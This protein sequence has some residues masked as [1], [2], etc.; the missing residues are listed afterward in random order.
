MALEILQQS[1]ANRLL[2]ALPPDEFESLRSRLEPIKLELRASLHEPSDPTPYVHFPER[3]VLSLLTVLE[4]GWSVELGTV[5]NE[6]MVDIS[7]ALG[8]ENSETQTI[9]QVPGQALRMKSEA[10]RDALMEL[11]GLRRLL[12]AYILEVF[13]MTAQSNACNRAHNLGQRAARWLLMTHDRVDADDFPL[14]QEFLSDM[15]G[16]ARPGVTV[17]MEQLRDAGLIR[18]R[19][20]RLDVIDRTGLEKVSCECY[21]LIRARFDRLE[22]EGPDS[23]GR[24]LS[25]GLLATRL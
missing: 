8:K 6:G 4:N 2:R 18:Y 22:G 1:M 3:G 10:F 17:A 15:L 9:V 24:R 21:A 20:G 14:T 13:T 7:V 25:S 16:A 12:S 5:G 23:D 19:R 11:P